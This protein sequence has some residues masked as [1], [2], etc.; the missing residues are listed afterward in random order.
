MGRLEVWSKTRQIVWETPISKITKMGCWC[1]SSDRTPALQAQALSSN[2]SPT[3]KKP[4]VFYYQ[5]LPDPVPDPPKSTQESPETALNLQ[6]SW[7]PRTSETCRKII[8]D[9]TSPQAG[10]ITPW[11]EFTLPLWAKEIISWEWITLSSD[12]NDN[13]FSGDTL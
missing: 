5:L 6:S 7:I 2:T 11:W 10:A 9:A 3:K 12:D 4:K 13:N 8:Q 1:D